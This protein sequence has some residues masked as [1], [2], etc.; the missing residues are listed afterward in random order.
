VV[1]DDDAFAGGFSAPRNYRGRTARWLYGAHSP[2]GQ[3]TA[4]FTV[5]G[6]PG[7]GE[8]LIKGID[9]ETGGKTPI[10]IALNATVLYS[11][12]NPLP[13]DDWRSATAPWG[14]ATFPIPKGVLRSGA[15]TLMFKNLAPVNNFSAPPYFMLDEA[16]VTFGGEASAAPTVANAPALPAALPSRHPSR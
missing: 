3:M 1:L 7:E 15:N 9:S 11:G 2:Y 6:T 4:R 10:E 13:K 16:T 12:G 14:E 5:G 8:L